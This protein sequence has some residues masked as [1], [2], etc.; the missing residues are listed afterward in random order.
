M[1]WALRVTAGQ[2]DFVANAIANKQVP[3]L[4]SVMV[5]PGSK[6]NIKGYVLVEAANEYVVRMLARRIPHVKGV[7]QG[8]TDIEG[9]KAFL[10]SAPLMEEIKVG[11]V[12]KVL[13][14]PFKG[15][16][17]RVIRVDPQKEEVTV[18]LLEAT[19]KI[20]VTLKAENVV[21]EEVAE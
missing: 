2:E 13:S 12:V 18:E 8:A 21:V 1:I 15:M 5:P 19:V 4:C 7:V 3:G 17:A 9:I 11:S 20:P 6:G 16:K 14:G 10:V